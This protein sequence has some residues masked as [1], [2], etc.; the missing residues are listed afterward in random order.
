[1]A[2]FFNSAFFCQKYPP[3][4]GRIDVHYIVFLHFVRKFLDNWEDPAP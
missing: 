2:F 3:F 1:M 4:V